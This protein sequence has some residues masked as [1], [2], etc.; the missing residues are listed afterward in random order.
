MFQIF[1]DPSLEPF[2]IV[3]NFST[4]VDFMREKTQFCLRVK[5]E[6]TMSDSIYVLASP[7]ELGM[8]VNIVKGK[9]KNNVVSI[10][11]TN[12]VRLF[13][14]CHQNYPLKKEWGRLAE[15][16]KQ[17][18]LVLGMKFKPRNEGPMSPGK[19]NKHN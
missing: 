18:G 7:T 8:Y 19:E 12:D 6:G 16:L 4:L 11:S 9:P 3:K 15:H 14:K 13:L 2:T 1:E 10:S 17:F 5:T